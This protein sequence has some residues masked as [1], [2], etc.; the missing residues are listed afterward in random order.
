MS[1]VARTHAQPNAPNGVG[2]SGPPLSLRVRSRRIVSVVRGCGGGF[3][4]SPGCPVGHGPATEEE[5][6]AAKAERRDIE[7][8]HAE[9]ARAER[10]AE[11]QK[12][13]ESGPQQHEAAA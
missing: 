8:A 6:A 3:P 13:G 11:Q 9:R 4:H 10:G 12:S 7:R 1:P 5:L 2:R